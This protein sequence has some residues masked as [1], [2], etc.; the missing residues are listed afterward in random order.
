MTSDKTIIIKPLAYYK[1]LIHVLRFGSKVRDRKQYKEVMGVLIGH[2]EG[3]PDKKGIKDVIVEDAV[4]ISHGG[5]IEVAF[6]PED[7]VTFS[8]VDAAYAEKG[9]FSIG[10]Y[11]SHPGLKIFFSS[12][13]VKNMLGW[14]TPNPSAI[15]I[16]FDHSFLE[17][18]GDMGFRTF[19]LDDPSKGQTTN[20][21]E[22]TTIVEPPD[23]LDYYLKL[24]DL[25]GCIHS[26]EPPILE[27]NEMP[28]LFGDI[29]IPSQ[30]QLT[31]KEPELDLSRI[32]SVLQN[33]I[34]SFL[35]L[36]IRPLI[37]FLN[38]W[39]QEI[40]KK[41]RDSNLQMRNDVLA[42]KENIGVG[43]SNIQKDFKFSLKDKLNQL[44]MYIDDKF[45]DFDIN[46]QNLK[47]TLDQIKV[48][49]KDKLDLIFEEKF[50]GSIAQSMNSFNEN[51]DKLTKINQESSSFIERL[52]NQSNSLKNLIEKINSVED[53]INN[54][55][56]NFQ[57]ELINKLSKN[58]N[59][60]VG[61]FINLNK[62]TKRFLSDLKAAIILLESSKNPLQ[63][64]MKTLETENKA[65]QKDL[66]L[67]KNENQDLIKKLKKF[68]GGA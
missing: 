14:Q 28:D 16:V 10:W 26:K 42:I 48:E 8:T 38:M 55:L 43:I 24:M 41:I 22:V 25:I 62:D 53:P 36:S 7:Y 9:W 33:G 60:V 2:L 61:N 65:L 64:K 67:L 59:K 50:K 21:H 19:R 15:G 32:L 44:D 27:I 17:T 51:L 58:T 47:E 66:I 3:E 23:S 34:S 57:D 18:P 12:T 30:N 45:E 1:M 54:K 39:S 63:N 37:Q 46:N 56:K 52:E 6:A 4:P 11:H 29:T 31:A 35:E 68:E 40:I 49:H 5:S 13:D 20:Y